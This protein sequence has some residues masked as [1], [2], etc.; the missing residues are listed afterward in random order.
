M[1]GSCVAS[2]P[3]SP[4]AC[5]S[6]LIAVVSVSTVYSRPDEAAREYCELS[7]ACTPMSLINAPIL[8]LSGSKRMGFFH[9]VP[10]HHCVKSFRI[11]LMYDNC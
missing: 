11:A 2:Q 9:D 3:E 6:A 1:D 7:V 4:A 5:M 8:N 10:C